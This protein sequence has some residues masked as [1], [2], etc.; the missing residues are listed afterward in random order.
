MPQI[1]NDNTDVSI[2]SDQVIAGQE[3]LK[4][5]AQGTLPIEIKWYKNRQVTSPKFKL[6]HPNQ[7]N[8]AVSQCYCVALTGKRVLHSPIC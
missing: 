4:C 2:Y 6:Y 3:V 8:V 7:I 1:F 5:I